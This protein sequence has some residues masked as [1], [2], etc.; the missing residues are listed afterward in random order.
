MDPAA[1]DAF[2]DR[3]LARLAGDPDVLGLVLLGSASGLPPVPDAFSDHDFFV[4]TRDGAQERFREDRSWLPA[5]ERIVL[6][7][8]ETPHGVKALW[9]DGHLAEWA[10]FGLDE[11]ALARVNR[12]RVLLDRADVAARMERV[13]K[14]TA[15][16]RSGAAP[17]ERWLVGMF[18]CALVVG[19]G[20]WARGERLSGHQLVRCA[21]VGHLVA[22]LR[23]GLAQEGAALLDD[24]DPLRRL[25][26]AL[27]DEAREIDAALHLPL[28]AGAR[29]LLAIATRARPALTPGAAVAAVERALD[30]ADGGNAPIG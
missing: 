6:S 12:Y 30:A 17:G 11:L 28:P 7:F 4:V 14:A 8:R 26:R 27:P 24:L 29:A 21:A 9:D 19:A 25:E 23:A 3:L 10:A 13:R 20:R 1:F 18:L 2:T 5:P 22:L 15:T 16:H